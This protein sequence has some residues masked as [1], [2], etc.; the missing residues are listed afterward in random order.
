MGQIAQQFSILGETLA[1]FRNIAARTDVER[2]KDLILTRRKLADQL[3]CLECLVRSGREGNT[4]PDVN[5]EFNKRLS[6]LRTAIA[7]HQASWPAVTIDENPEEYSR[8]SEEPASIFA[9]FLEWG[10]AHF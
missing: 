10:R 4:D 7:F 5:R 6:G 9:L 1:A 8:T 2:K 3:K